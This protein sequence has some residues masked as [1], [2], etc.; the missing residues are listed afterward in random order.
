MNLMRSLLVIMLAVCLVAIGQAAESLLDCNDC[1]TTEF[2]TKGGREFL[3]TPTTD[4]KSVVKQVKPGDSIVLED[5]VWRNVDL[6]FERLP[7]TQNAPIHI[8]S[9]TPGRV[10]F[11][12]ESQFRISGSHVTVSGFVFRNID[13]VSD[14]VQFRTHSQRLAHHC[15]ITDCIFEQTN[16]VGDGIES[17]WLSLYG[18]NNRVDHCYFSGKRSRGATL[19][20]WVTEEVETHRIDHNHFARR[21]ELGRNGGETI[22]IGTSD[23]SEFNSRTVVE[24]NYFHQCNGEA[25]LISNKSCENVYRHNVFDECSGTLTLRHGHRCVV[26]GN[27][28]L[29]KKQ[30][31]TGGVRIIGRQHSVTNN[32]FEGLRGDAERAAI[33]LMNGIPDGPLNGYAPVDGAVISHNTLVDCKVSIEFGVGAGTKQSS[34]PTNCTVTHNVFMP[35]KWALFRVHAAPENFVWNANKQQAGLVREDQFVQFDLVELEYERATDGLFRP[36]AIDGLTTN[37]TSAA[38]HD[39]DG[40][41]RG[42]VSIVGCDDPQ[43][44]FHIWPTA[45]NTGPTWRRDSA[46]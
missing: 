20:V 38:K 39:I 33:C 36:K 19:V 10:V 41:P 16:E 3:L 4:V 6:K 30:R 8:R 27:V 11:T 37:K 31:G 17:R 22:R 46:N 7:G 12:G 40:Q 28:F 32:Y 21:P 45:E 18:A 9:A 15:R 5:G 43:T 24:D 13:R 26:D 2:D 34:A 23:V 29:G 14:P 35:G 44:S 42:G 25:E 1:K